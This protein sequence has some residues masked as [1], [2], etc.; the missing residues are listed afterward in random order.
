MPT[1]LPFNIALN[2]GYEYAIQRQSDGRIIFGGC[3]WQSSGEHKEV[4]NADDSKVDPQVSRGLRECISDM[5]EKEGLK[6][7][8]P[9]GEDV[10][11][12][13]EWTGVMGYTKD[14]KPLVGPLKRK[15]EYVIAG[16]HGNGMPQCF[17]CA[18]ALAD[19]IIQDTDGTITITIGTRAKRQSNPLEGAG[20]EFPLLLPN[21]FELRP[22]L[23]DAPVPE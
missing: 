16:F 14:K 3:R 13:Y 19:M 20:E 9:K 10:P 4:G 12:D 6:G 5:W 1:V 22:D 7:S 15:G 8:W 21:R 17:A 2:D 18:K 23:R 11:V